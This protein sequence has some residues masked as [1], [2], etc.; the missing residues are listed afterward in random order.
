MTSTVLGGVSHEQ[1]KWCCVDLLQRLLIIWGQC[2]PR[3]AA[4]PSLPNGPITQLSPYFT[5]KPGIRACLIYRIYS[6]LARSA[7]ESHH[8]LEQWVI[9]SLTQ[10]LVIVEVLVLRVGDVDGDLG[11]LGRLRGYAQMTSDKILG[12]SLRE[13]RICL[14][15]T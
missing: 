7:F 3:V 9:D 4:V 14:K 5:R 10:V 12:F 11:L 6:T 2:C 1:M 15:W 13:F 8:T